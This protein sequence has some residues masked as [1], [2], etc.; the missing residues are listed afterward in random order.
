MDET[1]SSPLR[2]APA[3]RRATLASQRLSRKK[4]AAPFRSPLQIKPTSTQPATP[5]A[6]EEV[7]QGRILREPP[8][9]YKGV[10]AMAQEAPPEARSNNKSLVLSSRAAAQFRS[11]LGNASVHASRPIVLPNQA[12]M[13][14]ERKVAILRRAV[15]IKRDGD[16]G[17]LKCLTKKWRDAGR[18]A[19]YELWSIVRDFSTE[20]GETRGNGN[21]T[22]WG[23][24]NRDERGTSEGDGLD[25]EGGES[26]ERQENTLGVMLRKLG[27]APETLGWNEEEETFVDDECE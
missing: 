2:N 18:E 24:D 10:P 11:P 9:K 12:I 27:I 5:T 3:P 25:T 21:D 26:A 20:G 16:E 7:L 6:L 22:G 19:A 23:W 8:A 15:K 13:N 14:L 4:L 1:M 17:H